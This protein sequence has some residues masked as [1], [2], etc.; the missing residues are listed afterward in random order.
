[1]AT[2]EV[3][4]VHG[5]VKPLL[6]GRLHIGALVVAVPAAIVLV[7][8]ASSTHARVAAAV[9]GLTLIALFAVSGSYH[10]VHVRGRLMHVLRRAD[11]ATIYGLIAG[12]YTP[13]AL[14]AIGGPVGWVLFA[15][16]WTVAAFG[17]SLKI[18]WFERTNTFGGFLYIF[19]GWMVLGA[20]P[21]VIRNMTAVELAL[22]ALGGVVYTGGSIVLA[23]RRPNPYPRVF[24]YHELWHS[25][26]IAAAA[27]HYAAI[28]LIVR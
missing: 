19:M 25:L 4:D 5:L 7:A 22:F 3:I 13:V 14:V 2:T 27:C 10:R 16:A 15:A 11:H 24:G 1:M 8:I 20:A 17:M 26:V 6:R 9:Y 12:S 18:V 28:V 21:W 23:T